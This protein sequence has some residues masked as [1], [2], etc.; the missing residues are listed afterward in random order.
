MLQM[1]KKYE[2]LTPLID[3][4]ND[5]VLD[6]LGASSIREA[7][8]AAESFKNGGK[9]LRPMLMILSS[10][11]PAG[12]RTA[13]VSP[14]VIDLAAAVELIH[15]ATLFH[16]D[17]IDEVE[18]RRLKLSARVK[19]GNY[20]SVLTGDYV[21]AEAL[22]LVQRSEQ[23]RTMPDFLQTIR[24][25]VSGESRETNH[26]F[27]FDMDEN[28][29]YE[30]ISEKSAS[31][32]ALSCKSGSMCSREEDSDVLGHLGWNLGMAFQMI[33]DLDD[34]LDLPN[35]T[36]DCDLKNGYLGL[37]II[38]ALQNLTDG[39]RDSLIEVIRRGEFT[40]QDE[41]RIVSACHDFGGMHHT[42]ERIQLHLDRAERS[43][44]R[45]P[46]SDAKTLLVSVITDLRTYN[47]AQ[48]AG[49]ARYNGFDG[50]Q[51]SRRAGSAHQS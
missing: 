16:D 20:I 17:V 9:R 35:G 21:L 1:L 28:V 48:L 29:Y 6:V 3:R 50:T 10:L 12:A 44:D 13:N 18:T 2:S 25:L 19:Y 45:F 8:I 40:D 41:R 39:H 31:L 30:I 26:K 14:A 15:L 24:V 49:F 46:E 23:L 7:K 4:C 5:V 42:R 32:F 43:L 37:P 27:D 33:D 36:M 51:D 11:A 47:D 34:M 38:W 22:L